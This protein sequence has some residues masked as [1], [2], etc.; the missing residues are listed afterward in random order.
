MLLMPIG[1]QCLKPY[2]MSYDFGC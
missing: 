1:K 2:A